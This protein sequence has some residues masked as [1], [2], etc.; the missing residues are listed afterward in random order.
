MK[1]RVI[2]SVIVVLFSITGIVAQV[3]NMFNYQA[4]LRHSDGT[5]ISSENVVLDI[6]ILQGSA[7]GNTVFSES[8]HLK[9]TEQGIVNLNIGSIDTDALGEIDWGADQYFVSISV[10]GVE[11]GTKQLLSVPYALYSGKAKNSDDMISILEDILTAIGEMSDDIGVMADRI[12]EMS[13][14][15]LVMSDNIVETEYILA[16]ISKTLIHQDTLMLNQTEVLVDIADNISH[17]DSTFS[18]LD[19]VMTAGS[20]CCPSCPNI[21]IVDND[22]GKLPTPNQ[23][24]HF[25]I[26]NPTPSYLVY[27]SSSVIMSENTSIPILVHDYEELNN[28]WSNLD[29]LNALG[30]SSGDNVYIA[31]KTVDGNVISN[32][33]NILSY[34]IN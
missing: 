18:H 7:T 9:T 21:A 4:V 11:M 28:Q 8:H 22:D 29:L 20:N 6:S 23:A 19:S 30:L 17:L 13:D 14:R 12:G 16:D 10:N 15:I 1:K 33:S 25:T 34:L 26:N 27:V 2:L 5:I 31:V 32:Q 24:P 3:P